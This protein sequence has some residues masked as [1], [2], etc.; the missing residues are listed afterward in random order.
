MNF[1]KILPPRFCH[2]YVAALNLLL[3]SLNLYSLS[4]KYSQQ[5][6]LAHSLLMSFFSSLIHFK[7]YTNPYILSYG[8]MVLGCNQKVNSKTAGINQIKTITLCYKLWE[9]LVE[10][11]CCDKSSEVKVMPSLV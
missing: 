11:N 4:S 2:P 5:A 3:Y 1:I 7:F 6:Y 8:L 10:S 9:K